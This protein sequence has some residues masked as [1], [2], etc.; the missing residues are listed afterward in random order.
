M[1]T[2]DQLAVARQCQELARI[3]STLQN[4]RGV[5]MPGAEGNTPLE[6]P[7]RTVYYALNQHGQYEL[8]PLFVEKI[9]T[10][11]LNAGNMLE[12]LAR[13]VGVEQPSVE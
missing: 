5:T 7:K 11:L 3:M 6:F 4:F 1:T 13:Q 9:T 12:T 2:T 8:S 10:Y